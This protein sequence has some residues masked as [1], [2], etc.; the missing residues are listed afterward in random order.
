MR[1]AICMQSTI[2][3]RA[4]LVFFY[5]TTWKLSCKKLRKVVWIQKFS[6]LNKLRSIKSLNSN[7]PLNPFM[8]SAFNYK[9]SVIANLISY[10]TKIQ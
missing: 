9:K 2:N 6:L 4:D 5:Q 8:L 7:L 3:T 10:L 1:M